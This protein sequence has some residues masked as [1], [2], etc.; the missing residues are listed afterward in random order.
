M[1][2]YVITSTLAILLA[3]CVVSVANAQSERCLKERGNETKPHKFDN[4][5]LAD[6]PKQVN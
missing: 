4:T 2:K 6:L 3:M 1:K 5:T